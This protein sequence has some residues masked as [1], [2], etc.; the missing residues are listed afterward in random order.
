MYDDNTNGKSSNDK[1]T[2]LAREAY[3]S[4]AKHLLME[5]DATTHSSCPDPRMTMY[6]DG[7]HWTRVTPRNRRHHHESSHQRSKNQNIVHEHTASSTNDSCFFFLIRGWHSTDSNTSWIATVTITIILALGMEFGHGLHVRLERYQP[8]SQSHRQDSQYRKLARQRHRRLLIALYALNAFLGYVVM[9]ICMSYSIQLLGAVIVGLMMGQAMGISG[10][11]ETASN[12]KG[13]VHRTWK[14]WLTLVFDWCTR[15]WQAIMDAAEARCL[16]YI[17]ATQQQRDHYREGF[18]LTQTISPASS[19]SPISYEHSHDQQQLGVNTTGSLSFDNDS[20]RR[21]SPE[22]A[23][24]LRR[25][26]G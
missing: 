14:Q 21:Q 6:M 1:G 26:R 5:D 25:K 13:H 7:F 18:Q 19:R 4:E 3:L 8:Q 22:A 11:L 23:P 17:Q 20:P 10:T 12:T 2:T 16:A 24:L 9:L 15:Q